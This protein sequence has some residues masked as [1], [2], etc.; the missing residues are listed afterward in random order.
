MRLVVALLVAGAV[1]LSPPQMYR[2]RLETSKGSI[3]IEVHRDWAPR[4]ADR[5]Y[6]LVSAG[7]Y[8]D[9]R[10]FRVVAGRWAQFGI[11]GD[12]TTAKAWR[13]R[14]FEDDPRRVSNVR[15]TVAFAF[16]VPGGRTTQVYIALSDL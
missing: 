12:P 7:Y 11:S 1:Q 4:G 8:D 13:D 16:A 14:P 9:N 5:F 15:G 6:E 2:A 3:V 10:F